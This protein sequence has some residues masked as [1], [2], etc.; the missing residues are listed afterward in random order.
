MTS[1]LQA[2]ESK[3]L[4]RNDYIKL[5][6]ENDFFWGLDTC[7]DITASSH[8]DVLGLHLEPAATENGESN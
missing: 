6:L 1:Y 8:C 4:E 3:P 7:Q 5:I 2:I